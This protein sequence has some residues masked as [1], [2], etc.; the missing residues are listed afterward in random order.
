MVITSSLLN[1]SSRITLMR[2]LISYLFTRVRM[3]AIRRSD[4]YG[5]VTVIAI[6]NLMLELLTICLVP[7]QF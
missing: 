5:S 6:L 7:Q 1:E 3:G 2:Y 4:G